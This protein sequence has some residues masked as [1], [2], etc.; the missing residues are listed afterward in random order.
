VLPNGLLRLYI[1]AVCGVLLNA[2]LP[3]SSNVRVMRPSKVS[4]HSIDC[5]SDDIVDC[6]SDDTVDCISDDTVDFFSDDTG[7]LC[8]CSRQLLRMYTALLF[9]SNV[10]SKALQL[11]RF[12]ANSA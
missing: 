11:L 10:R 5:I 9:C 6:I 7:Q 1:L 8:C 4:L 12:A 2:N 3:S